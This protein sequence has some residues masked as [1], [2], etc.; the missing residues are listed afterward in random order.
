MKS[1][2]VALLV[3][4]PCCAMAFD[5]RDLHKCESVAVKTLTISDTISEKNKS[6]AS[7]IR[8]VRNL[9]QMLGTDKRVFSSEYVFVSGDNELSDKGKSTWYHFTD[10]NGKREHYRLYY[11]KNIVMQTADAG[12]LLVVCKKSDI[13][14]LLLVAA[15]NSAAASEVRK[16]LGLAAV[17]AESKPKSLWWRIWAPNKQ[18]KIQESMRNIPERSWIRIYFTPGRDC[19]NNIIAEIQKAD[20]IEIA[21]FSITNRAI[22]DSILVAHQ[23]G[24]DIRIITDRRQSAGIG[25][26]VSELVGAGIPLRTNRKHKIEHNKFAVFDDLHIVSGSYN[27]TT[28]ASESNSE[29]CLFFDQPNKEFSNRFEYLWD[30][31][32]PKSQRKNGAKK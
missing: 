16:M 21:V 11:T 31:Y 29:N 5:L 24:T 2:I 9:E 22:V 13:D 10:K 6:K 1:I 20:K 4:L 3:F 27:W 30:L 18:E 28:S 32:Q 15:K 12:D 7:E 19:E 26:L 8:N 14:L 23:R 25:S 17:A